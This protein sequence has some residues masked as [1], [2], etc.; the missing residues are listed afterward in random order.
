MGHIAQQ[1][2]LGLQEVA[3]PPGHGVQV[4][5]EQA[6]IILAALEAAGDT[7]IQISG[8][9]LARDQP[10]PVD[11]RHQIAR[12]EE[13]DRP[14]DDQCDRQRGRGHTGLLEVA[15]QP[16]LQ[17]QRPHDDVIARAVGTDEHQGTANGCDG[18]GRVIGLGGTVMRRTQKT[19]ESA[20][21]QLSSRR[22]HD[23][24]AVES[25]VGAHAVEP[26]GQRTRA[27]VAERL[28]GLGVELL[29][30]DPRALAAA[31]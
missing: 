26:L 11:R 5:R 23:E 28:L 19:G 14:A 7:H 27:A 4:G 31:L 22:V 25:L 15:E 10:Q 17:C 16:L 1:L 21:Q 24:S 30:L 12:Q 6:E 18:R 3:Q 20:M 9:Q 29:A 8:G 2:L 13:T